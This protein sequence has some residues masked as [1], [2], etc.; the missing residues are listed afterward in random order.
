MK[1]ATF[2]LFVISILGILS[3]QT[4]CTSGNLQD[5]Q[6]EDVVALTSVA[7]NEGCPRTIQ[8]GFGKTILVRV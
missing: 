8:V 2:V 7:Q 4:G 5:D 6:K 1:K 3:V